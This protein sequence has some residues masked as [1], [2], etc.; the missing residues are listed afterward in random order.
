MNKKLGIVL[1]LIAIVATAVFAGCIEQEAPLPLPTSTPTPSPT[2]VTPVYG[3]KIVNMKE[4]VFVGN[5]RC[6]KSNGKQE[7]S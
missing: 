7:K 2:D 3:Y 6:A 1:V 4:P 5:Q